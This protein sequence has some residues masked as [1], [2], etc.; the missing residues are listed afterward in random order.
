VGKKI[1]VFMLALSVLFCMSALAAAETYEGIAA[2]DVAV[3]FTNDVHCAVFDDGASVGYAKV[4][5]FRKDMQAK[6]SKV[7]LVD[8]GDAVHGD[9]NGAQIGDSS[10]GSAIISIMN[11]VGYDYAVLGNH[12]FVWG[13]TAAGKY[14]ENARFKYLGCNI[15]PKKG[16]QPAELGKLERSYVVEETDGRRIAFIGLTTPESVKKGSLGDY[17]ILD[18]E[19]LRRRLQETVDAAR[20]QGKADVVVLIAHIGLDSH[21]TGK[22][23]GK[24]YTITQIVR[25]TNGIDVVL[26]GHSPIGVG[27]QAKNNKKEVNNT[28]RMTNKDGKDIVYAHTGKYGKRIGLIIVPH[29]TE[30]PIMARYVYGK[31]IGS[32]DETVAGF[33][34]SL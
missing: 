31:D 8:A 20:S 28:G 24:R 6:C 10:K 13:V 18:R 30:K 23:K 34:E 7:I 14:L 32:G 3:I 12:E 2:D 15:E 16:A 5:R 29:D 21:L 17:R 19:E 26:D 4:A 11:E 22:S 1:L 33:I 27:E 25:D 9:G